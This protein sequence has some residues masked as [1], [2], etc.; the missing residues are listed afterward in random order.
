MS[1]MIQKTDDIRCE[2]EIIHNRTMNTKKA[3][4]QKKK[5]IVKAL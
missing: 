2:I 1:A 4:M 3:A 5:K